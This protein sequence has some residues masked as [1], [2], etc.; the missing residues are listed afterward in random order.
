M[1]IVDFICGVALL[2]SDAD[3]AAAVSPAVPRCLVWEPE[4]PAFSGGKLR[5]KYSS[6]ET[7]SRSQRCQFS[8]IGTDETERVG[9]DREDFW[10]AVALGG[11][12]MGQKI[13]AG[14]GTGGAG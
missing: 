14:E 7:L 12:K 11:A 5:S 8:G 1:A 9:L 6:S 2:T 4:A 10:P 3:V 13:Q